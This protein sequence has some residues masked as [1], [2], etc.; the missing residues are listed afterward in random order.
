MG[1]LHSSECTAL[2][3]AWIVVRVLHGSCGAHRLTW[4]RYMQAPESSRIQVTT[5]CSLACIA[6]RCAYACCI[7]PCGVGEARA[8]CVAPAC[9]SKRGSRRLGWAALPAV[10][11]F[12]LGR[13]PAACKCTRCG[14]RWRRSRGTGG[15]RRQPYP[16][17]PPPLPLR[18]PPS[19]AAS[20]HRWTCA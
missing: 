10:S 19:P 8:S 13:T 4:R 2:T 20:G 18:L 5:S 17:P 6:P 9:V 16:P 15:R 11:F 14:C 7:H 12:R 1:V 3:C